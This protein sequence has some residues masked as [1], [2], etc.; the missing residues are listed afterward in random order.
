MEAIARSLH[1]NHSL[2][3]LN[4]RICDIE[5]EAASAIRSL[6]ESNNI[7]YDLR[8]TDNNL[9]DKGAAEIISGLH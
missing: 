1:S 2:T 3:L 5:I 4:F 7:L 6:L 9:T 8:F